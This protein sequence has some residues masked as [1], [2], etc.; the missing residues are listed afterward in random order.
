MAMPTTSSQGTKVPVIQSTPQF[1][2]QSQ[3]R[4][5][6]NVQ[7]N[8]FGE[9]RVGM[10]EAVRE[11]IREIRMRQEELVKDS[12]SSSEAEEDPIVL[13]SSSSKEEDEE[14]T[15]PSQPELDDDP[16]LSPPT[17][18]HRH[19]TCSMPKKPNSRPKRK[20]YK[21]KATKPGS[22]SRKRSKD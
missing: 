3:Q 6:R 8:L 2:T 15:T 20:S 19:V 9:P 18:V 10:A 1:V 12:T 21:T 11:K 16:K 7:M 13:S 22:R 17:I 14:S 4:G 5:S